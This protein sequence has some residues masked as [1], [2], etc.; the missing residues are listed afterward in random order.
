VLLLA[1]ANVANLLLVRSIGRRRELAVRLSLGAS[2]GRLVR[3]MLT[4]S[5]LISLAG[6]GVATLIT[7]WT[8]GTFGNFIP[9]T[10]LPLALNMRVDHTVLLAT[11]GVSILASA[12][13]G[14]LPALRASH[15]APAEVLKEDAG[16]VSGGKHKALLS[17]G[18]VVAQI[19]LSLFLLVCAGL[20]IR[21]VQNARQFNP[22]FQ[23]DHVLL[24]SY[25][26]F[27]AGYTREDGIAFD[28]NLATRLESLPGV[29][30]ATLASWTPFSFSFDTTTINP[31]GYAPQPHESMNV[32]D[33]Q[34]APNYFRTMEIPLLEGRDFTAR[35]GEKAQLVAIVNQSLAERYWQG[36][37]PIGKRI[38]AHGDWYTVVGVA[39]DIHSNRRFEIGPE[40][41]IYLPL[42]QDYSHR[43][44][45][46]ARVAGEPLAFASEVEKAVH[47]LNADLPVY[48]VTTMAS[49]LELG[50]IGYRV[51]GTF[52]GAFGLLAMAL[53]AVGI[54][55]VI[56]YTTRQRTREI[57]IRIALG[58]QR[59]DIFRLVLLRGF[60]LTLAGLGGGLAMS[61]ALT[62]FLRSLLLGVTSTDAPT[63]ASVAMLLCA[64]AL[65]ACYIP[66]RR[67]VRVDPIVALRHE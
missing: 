15:L 14:I 7:T 26:L 46:E 45:I 21:S 48:D 49:Q 55:G 27:P 16:S 2:R 22:G 6:G 34:I 39:R 32:L 60:L 50:S 36:Q 31:E 28:R 29:K 8:A 51:A 25:D 30:S 23:P 24:V 61:L 12:I 63:Y 59:G 11:L 43:E 35:D 58:A 42:F 9:P 47:E 17:S 66:A 38:H 4:E 37:D 67:A 10:N 33:E 65:A 5:L 56:A 54:Y 52:V 1:C 20:F 44:T 40:P 19:S 64:V 41:A 3:Q 13:F 18:L 62:R 53:A 57:G